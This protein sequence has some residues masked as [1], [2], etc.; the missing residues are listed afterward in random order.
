MTKCN[1]QK[2]TILNGL[3]SSSGTYSKLKTQGFSQS[4]KMSERFSGKQKKQFLV[5]NL[6]D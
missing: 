6:S 3:G 1:I 2:V 5:K 4:M